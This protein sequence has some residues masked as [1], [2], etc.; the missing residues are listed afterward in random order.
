MSDLRR[1]SCPE[2]LAGIGAIL[3]M[4]SAQLEA[5]FDDGDEDGEADT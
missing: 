2:L 1:T 4:I 5:L 3:M